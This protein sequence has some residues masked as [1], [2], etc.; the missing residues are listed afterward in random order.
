MCSPTCPKAPLCRV[1][2]AIAPEHDWRENPRVGMVIKERNPSHYGGR[3]A[4][5]II[6]VDG[7]RVETA[8]KSGRQRNRWMSRTRLAR[9][10]LVSGRR[11][12]PERAVVTAC[13]SSTGRI[14]SPSKDRRAS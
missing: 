13:A 9:Y 8:G 3:V 4:R 12:E 1:E 14:G 6:A 7:A 5:E 2:K 10:D 11:F